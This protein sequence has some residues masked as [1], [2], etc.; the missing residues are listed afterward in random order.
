MTRH[1]RH[2]ALRKQLKDDDLVA[3]AERAIDACNGGDAEA[4]IPMPTGQMVAAVDVV[5]Q[6]DVDRFLEGLV[7]RDRHRGA[8]HRHRVRVGVRLRSGRLVKLTRRY[9]V[10]ADR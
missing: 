6:L 7:F 8:S 1:N 4:P 3:A 10:C 2:A 5:T 9:R